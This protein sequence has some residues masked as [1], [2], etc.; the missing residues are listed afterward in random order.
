LITRES[1]TT[2]EVVAAIEQTLAQKGVWLHPDRDKFTIAAPE[3]KLAHLPAETWDLAEKIQPAA[4]QSDTLAPGMIDLRNVDVREVLVL[5]QELCN[6]TVIGPGLA[7]GQIAV[8]TA[9]PMS[10]TEATYALQGSL[11]LNG[12][13]FA[14]VGD[15]FLVCLPR[16]STEEVATMAPQTPVAPAST[17]NEPLRAG[18]ITLRGADLGQ[19]ASLYGQLSGRAVEAPTDLPRESFDLKTQTTLTP[20]EA[21]Q[22][23]DLLL[24]CHGFSVVP[25]SAD[26]GLMVARRSKRG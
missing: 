21:L 13:K 20:S 1:A 26:K 2:E 11:Y 7:R 12:L 16:A 3:K 5:Y 18:A 17:T 6:R 4:G 8:C 23:L 10:R 15:K 9:T 14:A 25:S 19:I 22:A 24:A